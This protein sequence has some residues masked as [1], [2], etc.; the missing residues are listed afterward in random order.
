[1]TYADRGKKAE[2]LMKSMLMKLESAKVASHRF[3]DA[4]SGSFAVAPA[5][6][7][8]MNDGKLFM[9]EV[10]EVRHDYRLPFANYGKDQVARQRMFQ[11]A[12]AYSYCVIRHS[13][14]GM[15]RYREVDYFLDR[16]EGASWDLRNEP[17]YGDLATVFDGIFGLE[18]FND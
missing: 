8:V 5:D 18:Y 10:K 13:T 7:M 14:T 6:Y 17:A 4:H 15:W 3:P 16:S 9:L 12:G 2:G 11:F 1:M